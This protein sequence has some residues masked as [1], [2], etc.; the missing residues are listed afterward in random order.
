LGD[1]S[2][3]D[4]HVDTAKLA[5]HLT[6]RCQA[7]VLVGHIAGEAAMLVADFRGGRLRLFLVKIDDD[8]AAAMLGEDARRRTTDAAWRSAAGGRHSGCSPSDR[9]TVQPSGRPQSPVPP[10]A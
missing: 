4:E 9:R 7:G 6:E 10:E 5:D 2:I 3:V 8:H 1:S